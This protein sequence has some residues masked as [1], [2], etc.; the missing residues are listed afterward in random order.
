MRRLLSAMFL[1]LL[2]ACSLA[3]CGGGGDDKTETTADK[4]SA[5]SSASPTESVTE[6]ADSPTAHDASDGKDLCAYLK[7]LEPDLKAVGPVGASAQLAMGLA[8]W[9]GEHP[10]QAPADSME[11]DETT[12]KSCP[13]VRNAVLKDLGTKTL[14]EALG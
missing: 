1:P 11:M 7:K 3:A 6:A 12:K 2:L 9:V 14:Q 4:S 8:G 13:D 5:G 10:D